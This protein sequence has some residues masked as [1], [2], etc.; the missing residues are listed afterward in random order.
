MKRHSRARRVANAIGD[1][2]AYVA[3]GIARTIEIV[4]DAVL[5]AITF[6][7]VDDL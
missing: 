1:A 5:W 7:W 2:A 4:L 6:K 3:Y